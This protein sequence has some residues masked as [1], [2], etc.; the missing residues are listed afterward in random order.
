MTPLRSA[1][2]DASASHRLPGFTILE[3]MI[4]LAVV[5]A[6]VAIALPRLDYASFRIDRAMQSVGETLLAAHR[7]A[8]AKQHS[9][10]VTFD[11]PGRALTVLYDENGNLL[12]DHGERRR[13]VPLDEHIAFGRGG[14]PALAMGGKAI[15]LQT[16]V[17]GRPAIE[18]HR[19][20]TASTGGGFY[21]TSQR[22]AADLAWLTDT[23]ALSIT[24]GTV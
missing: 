6:V 19:D 24:E 23:R 15:N 11:V 22:A 7:H 1:P 3:V 2:A 16:Q 12:P 10:L 18:F 9:V 14:T 13:I 5:T 17:D 4:A 21:L 20:G 8:I